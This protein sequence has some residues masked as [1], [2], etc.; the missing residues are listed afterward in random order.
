MANI[1]PIEENNFVRLSLFGATERV[2]YR[3]YKENYQYC[4]TVEGS[5]DKK[6]RTIEVI[7]NPYFKFCK[8][9][10]ELGVKKELPRYADYSKISA[11]NL[12]GSLRYYGENHEEIEDGSFDWKVVHSVLTTLAHMEDADE[13]A[14]IMAVLDKYVKYGK[15]FM[16]RRGCY[17]DTEEEI[18][19]VTA[20]Y[21]ESKE[22]N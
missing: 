9:L 19:A 13:K 10:E 11:D 7:I 17:V 2:L 5:Y 3:E 16:D 1:L 22:E 8:E 14:A 4:T 6:T 18:E 21:L 12:W 15:Y 20:L